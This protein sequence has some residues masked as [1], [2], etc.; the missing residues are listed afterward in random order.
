MKAKEKGLQ[1]LTETQKKIDLLMQKKR[2]KQTDINETL[3]KEESKVFSLFLTERLNNLKGNERDALINKIDEIIPKDTKNEIWESNH[4]NITRAISKYIED[5]GK[6]PGK[7]FIANETGLSRQTIH[8]HLK[9]YDSNPFYAEE[10]QKFKFMADRV[11]AKVFR[12][13]IAGDTKAARLYFEVLGCL[14]NGTNQT[15]MIKNQNNYIQIN[16]RVLSQDAVKQLNS[17]QLQL[18]ESA[19]NT[20]IP[21]PETMPATLHNSGQ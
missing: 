21:Q 10:M 13:A 5:Y 17:E 3:N 1:N 16:G 19:L 11:L 12:I 8:A 4:M 20:A 7:T 14:G 6:M 18:I 15:T 9:E 2:I